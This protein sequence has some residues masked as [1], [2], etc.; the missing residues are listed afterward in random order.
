MKDRET[1]RYDMGFIIPRS[2][3]SEA[4]QRRMAWAEHLLRLYR[5]A[6]AAGE[7]D[8]RDRYMDSLDE[9]LKEF[10]GES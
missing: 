10:F 5:A 7:G 2:S 8:Q 3:G 9:Q 4:W 6:R 1:E